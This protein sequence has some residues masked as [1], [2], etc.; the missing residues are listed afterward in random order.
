MKK[1]LSLAFLTIMLIT[2]CSEN[3]AKIDANST[4]IGYYRSLTSV[5]GLP[6]KCGNFTG[7]TLSNGEFRYIENQPC[8][9][10]IDHAL[11]REFTVS[12]EYHSVD[13]IE[14]DTTIIQFLALLDN[15]ND[16]SNGITITSKTVDTIEQGRLEKLPQ[17]DTEMEMVVD[18]LK[19]NNLEYYGNFA[20][21]EQSKI[22]QEEIISSLNIIGYPLQNDNNTTLIIIESM[23]D[24]QQVDGIEFESPGDMPTPNLDWGVP[25]VDD[26]TTFEGIRG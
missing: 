9:L 2:G 12:D 3:D 15:D 23:L 21:Q 20:S 19:N 13:I 17:N 14:T 8:Q 1:R 26:F 11:I 24:M 5:E 22:E 4:K 10:Y 18:F 16:T 6:Y 25:E 7:R